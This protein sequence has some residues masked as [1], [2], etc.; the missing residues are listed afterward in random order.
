MNL[1]ELALPGM[2]ALVRL[3]RPVF[4]NDRTE[5]HHL[6]M[7]VCNFM[8]DFEANGY[9]VSP[10]EPECLPIKNPVDVPI[11]D[12]VTTTVAAFISGFIAVG[13]YAIILMRSEASLDA[14]GLFL[15][16]TTLIPL[17][18][19]VAI[20]GMM[21]RTNA[22]LYVCTIFIFIRGAFYL[23]ALANTS[24]LVP[25]GT[26][27]VTDDSA[28][29]ASMLSV[30]PLEELC[31]AT[32]YLVPLVC[33][34]IRF[35]YSIIYYAAIAGLVFGV[36]ENLDY[37]HQFLGFRFPSE[38]VV[39]TATYRIYYT[40]VLHILLTVFGSFF[41]RVRDDGRLEER[42]PQSLL[43]RRN[44]RLAR[45]RIR[46]R[47]LRRDAPGLP[48][49]IENRL[50]RHLPPAPL[51]GSADVCSSPQNGNRASQPAGAH[52]VCSLSSTVRRATRTPILTVSHIASLRHPNAR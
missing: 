6:A 14:S 43:A 46:S 29:L 18:V 24:L 28:W 44:R 13:V 9:K 32:I 25:D 20:F 37:S 27:H 50:G 3:S 15:L 49:G 34:R 41:S 47:P 48:R 1:S 19:F 17:T 33:G 10:I 4:P 11:G 23:I 51:R 38:F 52:T 21:F 2:V 7:Q 8:T 31:K 35:G 30:G 12:A 26:G 40:T 16:L 45:S 5:P 22:G 36:L 42:P 39:V